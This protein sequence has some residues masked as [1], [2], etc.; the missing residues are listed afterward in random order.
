MTAWRWL[1]VLGEGAEITWHAVEE[2]VPMI[3]TAC[4]SERATEVA[5]V[6]NERWCSRCARVVE[7]PWMVRA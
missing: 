7:C 1:R 6:E 2:G 4:G 5:V 3:A